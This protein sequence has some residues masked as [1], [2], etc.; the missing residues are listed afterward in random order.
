[1]HSHTPRLDCAPAAG[2]PTYTD[3]DYVVFSEASREVSEGR[4]PYDRA[5]YRYTPLL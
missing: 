2:K 1:M 3:I 5:T 4:S